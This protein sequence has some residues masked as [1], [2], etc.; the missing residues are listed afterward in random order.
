MKKKYFC[1][2]CKGLRNQKELH[3][4]EKRGSEIDDYFQWVDKYL[5]I[6]CEGC[7]TVSFLK[8]Y[9]NTE[10]TFLDDEGNIDYYDDE[11]IY[12]QYLEKS[13]EISHKYYL[14]KKIKEIYSE[15]INSLKSKSYILTAGGLRAT[16]EAICNHLKI[17][18]GN[19]EERID[20]LHGKGYLTISESKRLHSIRFLG[21]DALHEIETP[22]KEHLYILLDIINHLLTNLFINDKI[23]K[24]KVE[25]VID[26]FEDF[27]KL[28]QN[29]LSKD[30]IGKE[31][32]LLEIINNSKRL[33]PKTIFAKLENELI[34]EVENDNVSF[35]EYNKSNKK[36]LIKEIPPRFNFGIF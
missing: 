2:N 23:I 3:K 15:T 13:T 24:G 33:I 5:I 18:K 19:L 30:M 17:K 7:D 27:L 12:P 6:E 22:K 4:V 28:I 26:D 21:N 10:M 9:G 14:P 20:L 25:T 34:K 11:T 1:R 36:F 31:Y 29:K 8:I 35:L 16:I 32:E